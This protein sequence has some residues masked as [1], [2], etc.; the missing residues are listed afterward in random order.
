MLIGIFQSIK[1]L[2]NTN[3]VDTI[4]NGNHLCTQSEPQSWPATGT[5]GWGWEGAAGG[6]VERRESPRP[7]ECTSFLPIN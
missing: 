6:V 1:Q 2:R 5:D 4:D 7:E 3:S